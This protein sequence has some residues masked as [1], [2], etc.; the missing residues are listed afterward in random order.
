MSTFYYFGFGSNL[1]AKRIRVQNKSAVRIG[2]GKLNGFRL[3]FADATADEKYY[4]P[5]WAGSPATIV[6]S[7]DSTVFG[8]VWELDKKDLP[9]IDQ[10]EGVELGIYKPMEIQVVLNGA[11]EIT[12]RTY[13][14]VKNPSSPCDPQIR[15]FER[16]PSKTYLNLM[17]NGAVE[18]GLSSEYITF[19]K[20]FKH[21]GNSATNIELVN[22]LDL[23]N[24]L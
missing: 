19:L 24:L 2:V 9:Q 7:K 14:L 15:E 8:A 10:Q 4:S 23:K 22:Q 21:N 11:K 1:L 18:T 17:L 16:Q 5:T 6:E 20:S 12:C 13:Q 3:D